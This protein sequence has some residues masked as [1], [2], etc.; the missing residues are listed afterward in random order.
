MAVNKARIHARFKCTKSGIAG[1]F[2]MPEGVNIFEYIH[3]TSS[4]R[5]Q[6]QPSYQPASLVHQHRSNISSYTEKRP[7]KPPERKS[8]PQIKRSLTNEIQ[9]LTELTSPFLTHIGAFRRKL[10]IN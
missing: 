2:V 5:C 10:L 7:H 9:I 8:L 1:S 3:R 4:Q 6:K